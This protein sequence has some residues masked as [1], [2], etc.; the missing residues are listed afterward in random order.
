STIKILSTSIRLFVRFSFY[1]EYTVFKWIS[2][3]FHCSFIDAR[4]TKMLRLG[5]GSFIRRRGRHGLSRWDRRFCH[6]RT[7]S[8]CLQVRRRSEHP[9]Q[10]IQSILTHYLDITAGRVL[11]VITTL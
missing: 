6:C 11:N 8:E 10:S 2:S 3:P 5:R 4:K 1:S 7:R 9:E